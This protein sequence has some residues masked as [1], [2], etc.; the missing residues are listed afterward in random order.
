MLVAEQAQ[1]VAD[2]VL[3]CITEVIG[4]LYLTQD[5]LKKLFNRKPSTG[6]LQAQ[7]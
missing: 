3:G 2:E 5:S 6:E 7:A 4:S 1:S